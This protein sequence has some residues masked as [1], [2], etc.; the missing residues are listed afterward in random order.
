MESQQ[1]LS[2]AVRI[3][4]LNDFI[5]PSQSC[6]VTLKGQ[7]KAVQ[8]EVCSIAQVAGLSAPCPVLGL[9]QRRPCSAMHSTCTLVATPWQEERGVVQRRKNRLQLLPDLG[10]DIQP[11]AVDPSP[12]KVRAQRM[13]G[14]LLCSAR[15][16]AGW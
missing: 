8:E 6:V 2:G 4:D 7:K 1:L 3:S 15:A 13:G 14:A 5:A 12:V 9:F 10:S 16:A 11:Q